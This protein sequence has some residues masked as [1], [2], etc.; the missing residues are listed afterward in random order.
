MMT[1][2]QTQQERVLSVLKRQGMA[3]FSELSRGGHHGGDGR[4]HAQKRAHPSARSRPLSTAR[5]DR[6]YA[7]L[8]SRSGQTRAE[9]RCM[10]RF[11]AGFSLNSPTPFPGAYGWRDR[12]EGPAACG[13]AAPASNCALSRQ[14]P[15]RGRR[16]TPHRRGPR[17]ISIYIPQRR[18]WIFSATARAP[19]SD[20]RKAPASIWHLKDFARRSASARRRRPR[21]P[22]TR[23]R[24][25]S[26]KSLS[27]ILR[28]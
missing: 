21:S 8:P 22:N 12:A 9:R 27:L 18:S 5:R 3:R 26:G 23:A 11:S 10:P 25:E 14:A 2:G 19:A 7:P 15:S 4:A 24:R 6:G 28:R 13:H 1:E 17:F 20:I 16:G